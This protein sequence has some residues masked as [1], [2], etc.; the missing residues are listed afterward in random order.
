MPFPRNIGFIGLGTMGF[1]MAKNLQKNCRNSHLYVYDIAVHTIE[2]F[3]HDNSGHVNAC[4][5]PKAVAE[6]AVSTP[7]KSSRL[8]LV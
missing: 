2:S 8:I 6:K 5:S 4:S 1:P 3:G 7:L